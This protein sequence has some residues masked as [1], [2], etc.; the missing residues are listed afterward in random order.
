MLELSRQEVTSGS[1][2]ESF[3]Q[4]RDPFIQLIAYA[5]GEA[6]E[7]QVRTNGEVLV[8]D[9]SVGHERRP[10]PGYV[11]VATV[12]HVGSTHRHRVRGGFELTRGNPQ[13]GRLS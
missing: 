13:R 3:Q 10:G 11:A 12:V 9:G 8:Q 7:L 1:Q 4:V 5:T 6:H 2:S